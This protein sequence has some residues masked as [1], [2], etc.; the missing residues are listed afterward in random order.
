MN[1]SPE[2]SSEVNSCYLNNPENDKTTSP[3][4]TFNAK[5][6]ESNNEKQKRS[7]NMLELEQGIMVIGNVL[8]YSR[9]QLLL[10]NQITEVSNNL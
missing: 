9:N 1:W 6:F 8:N 2:H 4:S 7:K 5:Y 3:I 10:L